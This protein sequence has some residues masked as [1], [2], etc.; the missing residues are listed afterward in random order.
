VTGTPCSRLAKPDARNASNPLASTTPRTRP[1]DASCAIGDTA[2]SKARRARIDR[3]STNAFPPFVWLTS[4][5]TGGRGVKRRGYPTA[6]LLGRPV[7]ALVRR[8]CPHYR[9][10]AS[11]VS[12]VKLRSAAIAYTLTSG[13]WGLLQ[14]LPGRR[15]SQSA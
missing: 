3:D 15:A 2:F 5:V 8:R 14:A 11:S 1:G 4:R 12:T 10:S 6:R 9:G 13:R 7:D